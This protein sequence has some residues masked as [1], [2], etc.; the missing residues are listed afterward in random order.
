[1]AHPHLTGAPDTSG[2]KAMAMKRKISLVL[3]DV[4]GTLVTAEKVLTDRAR[5]AVH[6]LRDAGIRFAI[7]SGR[8]P[9]GMEMF[10]EPLALDTPLAGFNGGVYT[11]E[12]LDIVA[13][14]I[15][16]ADV[17][18]AAY[19]IICRQGLVPWV[20]SGGDWL[21]PDPDGPHVARESSTVGFS[22]AVAADVAAQLA[23][24]VK[25]VGVGDDHDAVRRCT[26]E[27]HT[28]LGDRASASCSQPYYLDIT[29][30][31]ANKGAVADYL[32]QTL[33]IPADEIATI[34]DG[35]NDILM[36]RKSGL[37]IAMGNASDAVKAAASVTTDSF[38]DEGFAKAIERFIMGDAT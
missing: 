4:D 38:A 13:E 28:V 2:G 18:A 7:T 5:R 23:N 34:G 19:D 27:V 20:Y 15:L 25:I 6:R 12:R 26:T 21:V 8:P 17:A 3:S 31:D 37:S 14:K 32:S 10:I 1:V 11:T 22:P 29:N 33:A 35:H 24:A 36:F 30:R 9:R 16:P